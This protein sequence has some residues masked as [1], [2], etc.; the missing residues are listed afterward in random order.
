MKW[1]SAN[2]GNYH[3]RWIPAWVK[4]MERKGLAMANCYACLQ[5]GKMPTEL[6]PRE[7]APAS[8][9]ATG[10]QKAISAGITPICRNHPS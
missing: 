4:A 3:S 1:P 2:F 6:P 7:L 9:S 10:L 5:N 8:A